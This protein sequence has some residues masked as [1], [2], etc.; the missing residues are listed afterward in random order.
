MPGGTN[1]GGGA[2]QH[3]PGPW[4]CSSNPSNTCEVIRSPVRPAAKI[5]EVHS[6]DG[7]LPNKGERKANAHLIA[8]AP[9]MFEALQHLAELYAEVALDVLG[10]ADVEIADHLRKADAALARARG[11]VQ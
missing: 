9:D 3:T 10:L 4:D 11:E 8:A 2:P 7:R 6:Y 1:M 5:A